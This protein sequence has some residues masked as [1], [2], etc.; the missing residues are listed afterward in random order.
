MTYEPQDNVIDFDVER[1]FPANRIFNETMRET[2]KLLRECEVDAD[3]IRQ[4]L[5]ILLDA[6]DEMIERAKK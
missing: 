3:R 1:R 6:V 5:F 2:T 4:D